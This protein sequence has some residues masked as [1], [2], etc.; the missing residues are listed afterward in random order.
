MQPF[1]PTPY[2][3]MQP[4]PAAWHTGIAADKI[5]GVHHLFSEDSD[6]LIFQRANPVPGVSHT[7]ANDSSIIHR[8]SVIEKQIKDLSEKVEKYEANSCCHGT[9]LFVKHA[10]LTLILP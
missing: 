5:K 6:A 10:S 3:P 9:H 4:V 2:P 8:I 1:P 7:I